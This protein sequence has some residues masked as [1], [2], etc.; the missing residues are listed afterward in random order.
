MSG[1]DFFAGQGIPED[2]KDLHALV[3]G[4]AKRHLGWKDMTS[5]AQPEKTANVQA[6]SV[7]EGKVEDEFQLYRVR[8]PKEKDLSFTGKCL[9]TVA[10]S[11]NKGRYWQYSVFQT[12]G[13]K[14][15]GVKEGITRWVNESDR[16]ETVVADSL[17]A[18]KDFF[19]SDP[20]AKVLYSRLGLEHVEHVE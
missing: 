13:G 14:F 15:V 5:S 2:F 9:S 11:D 7:D 17:D 19:G 8:R 4:Y 16:V 10:S 3:V 6:D 12:K 18:T 1:K 20:L